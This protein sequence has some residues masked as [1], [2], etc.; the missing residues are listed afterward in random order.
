VL[1]PAACRVRL[2]G[3]C[4]LDPAAVEADMSSVAALYDIEDRRAVFGENQLIDIETD[5]GTSCRQEAVPRMLQHAVFGV[6]GIPNHLIAPI[7]GP[8][9]NG[10]EITKA[11]S[12]PLTDA[13]A[14]SISTARYFVEPLSYSRIA[15]QPC[16][17][18]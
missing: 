8:H 5:H 6:I 18:A 7:G 2:G 1:V 16:A 12:I 9:L 11:V 4:V 14:C 13:M 3:G 15:S 10:H 17:S